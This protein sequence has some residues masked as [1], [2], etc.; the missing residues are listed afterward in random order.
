MN[1]NVKATIDGIVESYFKELLSLAMRI[2]TQIIAATIEFDEKKRIRQKQNEIRR[3]K[4]EVYFLLTEFDNIHFAHLDE[5]WKYISKLLTTSGDEKLVDVQLK[6]SFKEFQVLANRALLRLRNRAAE[7]LNDFDIFEMSYKK[8][9]IEKLQQ[10]TYDSVYDAWINKT[11][12][13]T[14]EI[15]E[16][17]TEE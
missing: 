2:N 16:I 5:F 4:S 13:L 6:T 10:L 1:E 12:P 9:I 15:I 17:D 11:N 7:I 8:E 3:I 14:G